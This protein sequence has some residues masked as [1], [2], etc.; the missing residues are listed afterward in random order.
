MNQKGFVY[1]PDLCKN[2][3]KT[4]D[5]HVAFH[6]CKQTLDHIQTLFVEKTGYLEVAEAFGIVVLF[7]QAQISDQDPFNPNGCW[8]FWGYNKSFELRGIAEDFENN[9]YFGTKKGKQVAAVW[10][11]IQDLVVLSD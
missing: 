8:D 9:S 2:K 4:C 5:L 3:R 11:I 1:I 7:P 6:G 10:K